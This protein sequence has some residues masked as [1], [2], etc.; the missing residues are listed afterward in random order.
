[1][2]PRRQEAEAISETEPVQLA[3]RAADTVREMISRGELLPGEKIRQIEVAQLAGVSR[4]PLREALRTLEGEGL[5]KYETNRGYV[6]S[7]LRMSELAEIYR[8]RS[9]L[10]AEMVAHIESADP[11]SLEAL[12]QHLQTMSA[13]ATEGD[14]DQLMVAYRAFHKV[15]LGLSAMPIFLSEVQRLWNMTDSYNAVHTLPPAIA[16]R[17]IRDHRAILRALRA[18]DLPKMREIA[19]QMP[20]IYEHVVVG[21]PSWR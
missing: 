17:I 18:D 5:V 14:F 12:E 16:R 2:P 9:L 8:M 11:E 13:A 19:A 10:E 21:L 3:A 15:Y 6:V 4:S 20:Q 1:M 7:R